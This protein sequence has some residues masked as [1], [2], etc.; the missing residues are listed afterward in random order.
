M[1]TGLAA[2][3]AAAHTSAALTRS[4]ARSR[5][6]DQFSNPPRRFGPWA[7]WWWPG[8][9]VDHA[10][11]V[12]DL[13]AMA[14]AG[15]AGAEIQPFSFMLG[16]DGE[17]GARVFGYGSPEYAAHLSDAG[18]IAA[19]RDMQLDYTF[20]SGWPFGGIADVTPELALLELKQARTSLRGPLA[21]A[22]KLSLPQATAA[23]LAPWTNE[24]LP[25]G[26][27][28]RLAARERLIAVVAVC[29]SEP[30]LDPD[31]GPASSRVLTPG[32]LDVESA[33]VLTDKIRADGTLDW[34]VPDGEWQIFVFK[35]FACGERTGGTATIGPKLILN[36]FSKAAFATYAAA[37]GDKARAA[38]GSNF[39][40]IV[41]AIFCDSLEL[42]PELYWSGDFLEAFRARAGY[43]LTPWL[44]ILRQPGRGVAN[45]GFHG[46]PEFDGVDAERVRHD[47]WDTVSA[48]ML[49]N[50][51]EPFAQWAHAHGVRAKVQA[52]GAPVD[53][54]AA[55][56][57][58]DIPET[59]TLWDHGRFDFLKMASSAARLAGRR[60]VSS[61]SFVWAGQAF[62]TTPEK[63][64][65]TAD[66]LFTAGVNQIL[67]HGYLYDHPAQPKNPFAVGPRWLPFGVLFSD[68]WNAANPFW[69]D[70]PLINRYI[71]RVQYVMQQGERVAPVAL[72][73]AALPYQEFLPPDPEPA[74]NAALLANGFD[75][76]HIN[77][78]SLVAA[79]TAGRGFRSRGGADFA[80]LV[81]VDQHRTSETLAQTVR[82]LGDAGVPIVF[83]GTP[84]DEAIGYRDHEVRS[85]RIREAMADLRA[86]P[87]CRFVATPGAVAAALADLAVPPNLHFAGP[88]VPF[89]HRRIAGRDCYFL[90]NTGDTHIDVTCRVRADG[91][92]ALL[93]AWTGTATTPLHVRVGDAWEVT[94]GL[95]PFGSSLLAFGAG[96]PAMA[97]DPV[98]TSRGEE[99]PLMP[100]SWNVSA[101]GLV[102][103]DKQVSFQLTLPRLVDLADDPRFRHFSG[104]IAYHASFSV[105]RATATARRLFLNLGAVFDVAEGS[106]N[107]QPLSV[108]LFRP[109]RWN[110]T[111][112][113]RPGENQLVITVRNT[114]RNAMIQHDWT[115]PGFPV[116]RAAP[117]PTGL[118]GP[119]RL[120]R[121]D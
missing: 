49:E 40:K 98:A 9:D 11:L 87:N 4:P 89:V 41:R 22:G 58:A 35:Q 16:A 64:K 80:A 2:I 110:V 97:R 75:F 15:F 52:H 101:T 86:K 113:L 73:Q 18:A 8:T 82:R 85:I 94:I 36:H 23:M 57:L 31:H 106:L 3:S 90:R 65:R 99:V 42:H 59:E 12:R 95:E 30:R 66:E 91:P 108:R 61:E 114:P 43:D 38:F 21:T 32:K 47:Y 13:G 6:L 33:V 83:V 93:D 72:Y 54:I 27:H 70:L 67:Y 63:I 50:F 26:W 96:A 60:L 39:G 20:G 119:L 105:D 48:L 37:I 45:Q 56:G 92:P 74:V 24:T 5:F 79:I 81:L 55:Y 102:A 19:A 25:P 78:A 28:D 17:A 104:T 14:D 100:R 88:G 120:V 115:I 68:A 109:Y 112:M 107:G 77:E 46:L 10:G 1:T 69:R 51:F 118:H 34:A 121:E 76:D 103:P 117:L 62:E 29:G 111:G 84:P 116:V 7:R 44:P 53:L 71:A